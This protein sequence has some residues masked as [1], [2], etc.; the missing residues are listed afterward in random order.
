MTGTTTN[1]PQS[2][3]ATV[4]ITNY[5]GTFTHHNDNL[6]TGQNVNETVLTPANVNQSQF[7]KLFSY[8]MD[9]IAFASPLYVANVNIP[10]QGIPQC[11]VRGNRARQCVCLGR[12]RIERQ[13][14]MEESASWGLESRRFRAATP[15]N[16]VTYRTKSGS[17]ERRRLIRRAG[18]CT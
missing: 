15:G 18:L 1:P 3:N 12:R 14:A 6:R 17:P 2:A 4:Y 11:G 16:A 7:G 10:G 9:G 13:P 5:P 8:T